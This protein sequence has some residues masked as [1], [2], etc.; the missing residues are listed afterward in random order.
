MEIQ[1][2]SIHFN[3]DKKLIKTLMD[4]TDAIVNI[5]AETHVDRSIAAPWPFVESNTIGAVTLFE[6]AKEQEKKEKF[7]LL[8]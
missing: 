8:Y 2:Q 3:A 6:A 4:K 5:A 7:L 1:I